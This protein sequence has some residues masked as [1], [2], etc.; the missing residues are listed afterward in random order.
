MIAVLEAFAPFTDLLP[1]K[2]DYL[3]KSGTLKGVYC[4]S[5]YLGG[6]GYQ[7]PF[8]IMLNQETN[9]RNQILHLLASQFIPPAPA[10]QNR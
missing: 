5:G 6:H 3:M 4:Y 1:V 2:H 8:T 7:T 9:S 10:E